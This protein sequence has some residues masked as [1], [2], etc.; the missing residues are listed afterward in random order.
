MLTNL[1]KQIITLGT[2]GESGVGKTNLSNVFIG[3][4]FEDDTISTI[5]VSSL[6]R[7]DYEIKPK[8]EIQKITIKIWDTA[9]QERY[10]SLST[11]YVKNCDGILLV[12]S[13]CDR[14]SFEKINNWIKEVEDKKSNENEIPVVLI[15]NKIDIDDLNN[16]EIKL[17]RQISFEEGKKFA[18]RYGIKFFECSA[19]KNI[20]VMESFQFL[21]DQIVQ[22]HI[23]EFGNNTIDESDNSI[24]FNN[25]N[26]G[27]CKRKNKKKENKKRSLTI[28]KTNLNNL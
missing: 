24:T 17:K 23:K 15:G 27:C 6:I 5:G 21:I 1:T 13:I 2:L 10:R 14:N 28:R 11:Q 4:K 22:I 19:K 25:N 8:S 16:S 9:G 12:Y 7:R 18:E 26:N 20:N 3:N